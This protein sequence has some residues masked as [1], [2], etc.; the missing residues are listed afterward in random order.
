M[1]LLPEFS[2][3]IANPTVGPQL[4]TSSSHATR[5]Q[6]VMPQEVIL[7]ALALR[8][9]GDDPSETLWSFYSDMGQ[10]SQPW[11]MYEEE[12]KELVRRLVL[13]LSLIHISEPTRPY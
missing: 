1:A 8:S 5:F 9:S 7:P 13:R 12:Q 10:H 3:S 11:A 2:H 6:D 4:P